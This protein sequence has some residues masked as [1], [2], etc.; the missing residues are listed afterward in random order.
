MA[1]PVTIFL[2]VFAAGELPFDF[3]HTF[4]DAN[5]NAIDLTGYT[6]TVEFEGPDVGP[7]GQGTVALDADPTT[8][9]VQYSWHVDD[10]QDVGKYE[11]LI[12]VANATPYRLAS[13]LIKYEVYD[14]P[15]PTPS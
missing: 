2:G 13:D 11:F 1:K 8:G 14:G 9:I 5:G 15:G 3:Q 4:K 7:Y 6:P 10:F 12:W